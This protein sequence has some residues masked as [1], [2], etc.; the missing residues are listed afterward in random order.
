MPASTLTTARQSDVIRRLTF[1]W[2]K[3]TYP[4]R[5][6][7]V[8]STQPLGSVQ[9]GRAVWRVIISDPQSRS[10]RQELYANIDRSGGG[11]KIFRL[12]CL[13][14]RHGFSRGRYRVP[15]PIGYSA[16]QHVLLYRSF[17]GYRVRDRL[18]AG[19]FSPHSLA[20]AVMSVAAWLRLMHRVPVPATLALAPISPLTRAPAWAGQR[21]SSLLQ[22][23]QLVGQPKTARLI[24]GDPHLANAIVGPNRR[25][26]LIDYSESAVGD[27]LADVAM[28]VVHLDVAL[29]PYLSRTNVARL[30]RQ[31]LTQ[32]FRRPLTRVPRS[33]E[34]RLVAFEMLVAAHFLRFTVNHHRRPRGYPGWIVRRL[35]AII[36]RGE[37]QLSAAEPEPLLATS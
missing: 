11:R 37:K 23:R 10:W 13:L 31:F 20:S 26:A 8:V 6:G 24:H 29:R 27:P 1:R 15:T 32:Y 16:R 3:R 2:L 9:V 28:F 36:D 35:T 14:E 4:T 19:R 30:Q 21:R 12:M 17:A 33:V 34:K 25:F 18:E 5:R 7:L 22:A